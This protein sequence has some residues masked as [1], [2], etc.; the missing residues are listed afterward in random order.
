MNVSVVVLIYVTSLFVLSLAD[1]AK[2]NQK[3][4]LKLKNVNYNK[5]DAKPRTTKKSQRNKTIFVLSN[6]VVYPQKLFSP[7]PTENA[8]ARPTNQFDFLNFDAYILKPRSINYTAVLSN[9]NSN[10]QEKESNQSPEP[11][12]NYPQNEFLDFPRAE[13]LIQTTVPPFL[14]TIPIETTTQKIKKPPVKLVTTKKPKINSLFPLGLAYFDSLNKYRKAF[15]TLRKKEGSKKSRKKTKTTSS[16]TT[17][18]TTTTLPPTTTTVTEEPFTETITNREYGYVATP[19]LDEDLYEEPHFESYRYKPRYH[20]NYE[21]E[22]ERNRYETTA[23][24]LDYDT[25][26]RDDNHYESTESTET[27]T[28][29]TK[30]PNSARRRPRNKNLHSS[31]VKSN[32]LYDRYTNYPQESRRVVSVARM[33]NYKDRRNNRSNYQEAR[34]TDERGDARGDARGT[35]KTDGGEKKH[36]NIIPMQRHYFQ[37]ANAINDGAYNAGVGKGNENHYI[38]QHELSVPK[39]GTFQKRVRW[40]DKKGGFGELYYDLNHH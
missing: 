9:A 29:T 40:N 33:D 25:F 10:V 3:R 31:S 15:D 35:E 24:Y 19:N 4:I 21:D 7:K 26:D 16:T 17:S 5:T 28:T 14:E 20:H 22:T 27:V 13:P 23:R 39:N 2:P 32:F 38:E 37:Y 30:P 34:K 36:K 1:D 11:T 18:T 8:I 12:T 6:P